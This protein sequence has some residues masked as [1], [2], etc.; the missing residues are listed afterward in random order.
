MRLKKC[1][2]RNE[3]EDRVPEDTSSE[4]RSSEAMVIR[5]ISPEATSPELTKYNVIWH[6]ILVE[7][8]LEVQGGQD[9]FRFVEGTCL[10][11]CVLSFSVL[12]HLSAALRLWT[13]SD[14]EPGNSSSERKEEKFLKTQFNPPPPSCGFSHLQNHLRNSNGTTCI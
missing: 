5:S 8:S 4:A 11:A 9:Y 2:W 3:S 6:Y 13:I 7:L 12:L 1:V 14:S 10:I